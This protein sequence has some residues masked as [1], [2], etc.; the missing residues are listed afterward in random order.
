MT[1]ISTL[2]HRVDG[3]N[4]SEIKIKYPI[5]L[6]I[7]FVDSFLS[8]LLEPL[9]FDPGDELVEKLMRKI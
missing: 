9:I 3:F 2:F 1:Q 7:E 4:E 6:D 5:V 8:H